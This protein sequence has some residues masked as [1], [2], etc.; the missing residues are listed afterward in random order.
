MFVKK[1][2]LCHYVLI[3]SVLGALPVLFCIAVFGSNLAWLLGLYTG[4]LFRATSPAGVVH[5]AV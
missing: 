4:R 5:S 3:F 2:V 1:G